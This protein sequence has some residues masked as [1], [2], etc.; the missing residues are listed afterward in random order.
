MAGKLIL[1]GFGLNP[2]WDGTAA[3]PRL[4]RGQA[5]AGSTAAMSGLALLLRL[6]PGPVQIQNPFQAEFKPRRDYSKCRVF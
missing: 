3:G 6:T 2:D 4:A 5:A 1:P